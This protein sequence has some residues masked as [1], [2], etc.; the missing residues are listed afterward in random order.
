MAAIKAA[1]GQL[2][3]DEM[4]DR[5]CQS[6]DNDEWPSDWVNVGD[7]VHGKPPIETNNNV[8]LSVKIPV[9]MKR[10]IEN[11]AKNAG[12]SMSAA[13]RELLEDGL[14]AASAASTRM[15]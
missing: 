14:M 11:R 2:V 13:A 8:V 10:A 5:W 15:G 4:I 12:I 3:T 7:I 9:G 6:L 1:N